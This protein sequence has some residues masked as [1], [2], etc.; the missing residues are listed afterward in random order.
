MKD[1]NLKKSI[2][3][4]GPS[5]VGKSLIATELSKRLG[6]QRV[7]IDDIYEYVAEEI[8]V[9]LSDSPK[10]QEKYKRAGLLRK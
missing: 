4:I 7:C 10:R 5:G 9:Q 3:L 6:I 8:D 1:S 2:V